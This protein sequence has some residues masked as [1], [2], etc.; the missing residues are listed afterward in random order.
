[1][2]SGFT[3]SVPDDNDDR[4]VAARLCSF[5]LATSLNPTAACSDFANSIAAT[6]GVGAVDIAAIKLIARVVTAIVTACDTEDIGKI[7][8]RIATRPT[9]LL[10]RQLQ[11]RIEEFLVNHLVSRLTAVRLAASVCDHAVLIRSRV[12]DPAAWAST[13]K[14]LDP[15]VHPELEP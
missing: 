9:R 5:N 4:T 6:A 12:H 1:M 8:D 15:T 3:V 13:C 2:V 10:A 14:K 11:G 7:I